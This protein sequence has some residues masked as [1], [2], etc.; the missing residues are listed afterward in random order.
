MQILREKEDKITI[1]KMH[2]KMHTCSSDAA[3]PESRNMKQA[4]EKAREDFFV[5]LFRCGIW[6]I[7]TDWGA[8]SASGPP[9][10]PG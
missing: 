3:L 1:G 2:E 9:G 10:G 4:G 5:S 7:V 6:M 8:C